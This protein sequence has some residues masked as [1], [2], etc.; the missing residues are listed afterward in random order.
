MPRD[1]R[2]SGVRGSQLDD[3]GVD[4]S[5]SQGCDSVD[6]VPYVPDWTTLEEF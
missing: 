5:E 4:P 6:V 2:E 3:G 1:D